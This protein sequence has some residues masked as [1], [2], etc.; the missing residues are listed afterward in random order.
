MLKKKF[1]I[2]EADYKILRQE[3]MITRQRGGNL[4]D[5]LWMKVKRRN[6]N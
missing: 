3:I 2:K 4:R 5:L 1:M 6:Y